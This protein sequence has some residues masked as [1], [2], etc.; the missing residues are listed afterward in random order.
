MADG[1]A[2]YAKKVGDTQHNSWQDQY[3][4]P[5]K[6]VKKILKMIGQRKNWE[7]PDHSRVKIT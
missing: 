3:N 6:D 7:I 1:T 5:K 2:H 4:Y